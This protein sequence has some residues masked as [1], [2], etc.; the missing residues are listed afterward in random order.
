MNQK[1]RL[2]SLKEPPRR[3]TS[4]PKCCSRA[5]LVRFVTL[6]PTSDEQKGDNFEVTRGTVLMRDDDDSS[7]YS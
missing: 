6:V 5:R 1:S 7:C 2:I 3:P 4:D